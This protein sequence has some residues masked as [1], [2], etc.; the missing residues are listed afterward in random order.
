MDN[1]RFIRQVLHNCDVSDARH[2]GLYSVCGLA[3]RLR[4]LF[5][6]ANGLPPW[7]EAEAARVLAWI[8]EKEALWETLADEE[9]T[10]L[11]LDGSAFGVFD[12]PAINKILNHHG[13]FYGAG[14]AHSLKPTFFVAEVRSRGTIAGHVVWQLGREYARDLL[15]LP[16]FSQDGQVVLRSE[17]ATLYLWDQLLYLKNSGRPA[18]KFA[19]QTACGLPDIKP[20]TLLRHLDAI[21][22]IQ[23]KIYVRHE[24][25]ELEERIFHRGTWR[26]MLADFAHTPVELLVRAL[27]DVLADT[28][29]EGAL[30]FL[31]K[32]REAAGL[33]LYLAFCDGLAAHLLADIRTQFETLLARSDWR[34]LSREA[35]TVRRKATDYAREIMSVYSSGRKTRGA[36][37]VRRIIEERMNRWGFV[38]P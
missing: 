28:G 16:A 31:I 29:A 14:Y 32:R 27:K 4:D 30:T 19:L 21:L 22:A 11:T 10:D 33:G 7:Q 36:P 12:T 3:M 34:A 18:L 5:K 13:L 25:G 8:G 9:Y 1:A 20:G 38:K 6:W 23:Q 24:I 37:W 17:A 35:G 2:A 26:R 15:T